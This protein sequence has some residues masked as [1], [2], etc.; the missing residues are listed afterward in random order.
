MGLEVW[1]L[2]HFIGLIDEQHSVEMVELVLED[3][4]V[5]SKE[6]VRFGVS[7]AV[8]KT[9]IHGPVALDIAPGA[10]DRQAPLFRSRFSD[11]GFNDFW[12]DEH[13]GSP[14]Q[15]P[16]EDSLVGIDL[17]S[18]DADSTRLNHR[19]NHVVKQGLGLIRRDLLNQKRFRDVSEFS[20]WVRE[21]GET[22]HNQ[23]RFLMI[24]ESGKFFN[25]SLCVGVG[26][27]MNHALLSFGVTS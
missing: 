25:S 19:Q 16:D 13:G 12:V 11:G 18:C 10:R 24:T 21:Y 8:H 20:V 9:H 27:V 3:D 23:V 17:C 26:L 7:R 14:L 22:I 6:A 15:Q 4:G 1:G 5:E 2:D